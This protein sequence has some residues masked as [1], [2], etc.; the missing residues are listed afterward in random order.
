MSRVYE[1]LKRAAESSHLTKNSRNGSK[2][3]KN[4]HNGKA[5]NENG[6]GAEHPWDNGSSIFSSEQ[7]VRAQISASNEHTDPITGMALSG[8][9]ASRVAGATLD[10]ASSTRDMNFPSLEVVPARV[11]PHL[12]AIIQ[13]LSPHAEQLRSLRTRLLQAGERRRMQVC[14]MTSAN[15][16]EGKTTTSL[17]LSW[18]L[19]QTDGV[20]AL[21]IDGDLRHPCASKYLGIDTKVGLSEVLAGQANLK[22]AIVKLNPAGLYLLPGGSPRDDVSE[23]LSGPT[24]SSVLMELRHMFDYIIIDAPPLGI[25]ADATILIN[26][27]DGALLVVRSG[28]T[29]YTYLDRLLE[30]LP[31][32][33]FL[34]VVLNGAQERTPNQAYHYD[35]YYQPRL[36]PLKS[37]ALVEKGI[38]EVSVS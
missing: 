4:S 31:K 35:R 1:A 23:M 20:K 22:D 32:E 19:A 25:F 5:A 8:V 16:M 14:V 2:Q 29:R 6:N 27:A 21:L 26:R 12:I 17:N 38:E 10:A 24:F 11:E 3:D 18:L 37:E 30:H 36:E 28:K 13:P 15:V 34:G 9:P 7:N 33:R